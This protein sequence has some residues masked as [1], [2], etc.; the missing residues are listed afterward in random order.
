MTRNQ[1][2]ESLGISPTDQA[3]LDAGSNHNY[4]CTCE[5]CCSWWV[6][7]GPDGDEPGHYGPFTREQVVEKARKMSKDEKYINEVLK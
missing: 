3:I 7:M 2:A 1:F 6:L 4:R 5:Q